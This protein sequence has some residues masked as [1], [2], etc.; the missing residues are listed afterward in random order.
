MRSGC[1]SDDH[2]ISGEHFGKGRRWVSVSAAFLLLVVFGLYSLFNLPVEILP[3]ITPSAVTVVV[4]YPGSSPEEVEKVITEKLEE[5]ISGVSG[6][7][8]ME[9]VSSEGLSIVKIYL[10]W[11][12][13][14]DTA[15]IEV[16]EKV[17]SIRPVLPQDASTPLVLKYNPAR[18]PTLRVAVTLDYPYTRTWIE[19]F[20]L[21][22]LQR[23]GGVA[24]VQIHGGTSPRV[25]IGVQPEKIKSLGVGYSQL[26][27][28]FSG[29]FVDLPVGK[30]RVGKEVYTAH[31]RGAPRTVEDI[32]CTYIPSLRQK[33]GEIADEIRTGEKPRTSF[34]YIKSE[35]FRNLAGKNGK[36][37]PMMAKPQ[38]VVGLYIYKEPDF[39]TLKF[40]Q[41]VKSAL[42]K[43]RKSFRSVN[44]SYT[45]IDD[46][47]E[48]IKKSIS[49]L[50]LSA[51]IGLASTVSV[52]MLFERDL[53]SSALIASALPLSIIPSFLG[54]YLLGRTLNL[55]SVAGL[56]LSLGMVV[57]ASIVSYEAFSQG[58]LS[59]SKIKGIF[60]A[61]ISSTLT[62][63]SVF[64]PL[65]LIRGLLG[66]LTGEIAISL[67]LSLLF[68]TLTAIF[69]VPEFVRLRR[70]VS[71][72]VDPY[73]CEQDL[74][75]GVMLAK[76]RFLIEKAYGYFL[77]RKFL[78]YAVSFFLPFAVVVAG[79]FVLPK[80]L[81]PPQESG[82]YITKVEFPI[83]TPI[84][85]TENY[86]RAVL[87]SEALLPGQS[88]YSEGGYEPEE[89]YGR[90][91]G[92][93]GPHI[94]WF[95]TN[96][97]PEPVFEK[98]GDKEVKFSF[99][100]VPGLLEKVL[101]GENPVSAF[102]SIEKAKRRFLVRDELEALRLLKR[103]L[104]SD[105]ARGVDFNIRFR[106]KIQVL[107]VGE[108][109]RGAAGSRQIQEEVRIAL[110]G[111]KVGE[112]IKAH[113]KNI[114]IVLMAPGDRKPMDF[115]ERIYIP[116]PSGRRVAMAKLTE[117]C[118]ITTSREKVIV[119]KVDRKPVVEVT[120]NRPPSHFSRYLK[121][122]LMLLPYEKE[123]IIYGLR[124]GAVLLLLSI[125]VI[126]SILSIQFE[127]FI[128]PLLLL[129]VLPF[130]WAF[131]FI[132]LILFSPGLNIQTIMGLLV[133]TGTVVN[134][135]IVLY[136]EYIDSGSMI[137]SL[138]RRV[139][140]VLMSNL[141]TIAGLV[142]FALPFLRSSGQGPLAITLIGGIIGGTMVSLLVFPSLLSVVLGAGVTDSVM[143]RR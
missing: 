124:E 125:L 89:W 108:K 61:I 49:A 64:L 30:L 46:R 79:W 15:F 14:P 93:R 43:A 112:M 132:F 75:E 42:E 3:D 115:L 134:N 7:A 100:K 24:K 97:P 120:W 51:I 58:K 35:P 110:R 78:L 127:S 27:N 41:S 70:R 38:R 116:V 9:S 73:V 86:A 102:V 131:S 123:Q 92:L 139:K 33:V 66:K 8:R 56:A 101:E 136:Q 50:I 25:V 137:L 55:M 114:P 54:L 103:E 69:F 143:V 21:P 65:A 91:T 45:F 96:F 5:A 36:R 53:Y 106:E 67:S 129:T 28:I 98:Y 16:K 87:N 135:S 126:Y 47:S 20:L 128:V 74:K 80:R 82:K 113:T 83:G 140:P 76:V 77:R 72:G 88:I 95:H 60:S 68:S 133:I 29:A 117:V 105:G 94:A 37:L 32:K 2:L 104:I 48:E 39:P 18:T 10:K 119:E 107:P 130:S 109:L 1:G 121:T 57:D 12:K 81:F 59:S 118:N 99:R 85:R 17:D 63:V 71:H 6:V 122:G 11:N 22:L 19:E 31:L 52:I 90:I 34:A 44:F 141:T 111:K 40:T 84:E 4:S 138:K 142:P 26:S 62:T 13:N 23:S